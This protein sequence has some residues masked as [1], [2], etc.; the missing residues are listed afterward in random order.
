M[1]IKQTEKKDLIIITSDKPRKKGEKMLRICHCLQICSHVVSSRRFG[2]LLLCRI[3]F[4]FW[5]RDAR[6]RLCA[7]IISW[8][9]LK[10]H[11]THATAVQRHY[12]LWCV[13]IIRSFEHHTF[14]FLFSRY[15]CCCYS[16][17]FVVP[18]FLF[19]KCFFFFFFFVFVSRAAIQC[20]IHNR[21]FAWHRQQQQQKQSLVND[22]KKSKKNERN[23]G[24]Y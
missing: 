18:R 20:L 9:D 23:S 12:L 24:Q 21:F 5:E 1:W 14:F 13:Q 19:I 22:K 16:I 15:F 6:L 7:C 11:P 8:M 3:D 4:S 2:F 10:V 17:F